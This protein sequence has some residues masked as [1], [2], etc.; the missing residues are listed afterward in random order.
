MIDTEKLKDI[1]LNETV[2]PSSFW[3]KI[4]INRVLNYCH[5]FMIDYQ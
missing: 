3:L 4:I 2:S 1:F 5:S